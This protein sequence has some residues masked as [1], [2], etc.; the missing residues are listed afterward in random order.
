MAI[1]REGQSFTLDALVEVEP[2]ARIT[3]FG[4]GTAPSVGDLMTLRDTPVRWKAALVHE[5]DTGWHAK[6]VPAPAFAVVA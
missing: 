3:I 1:H 5:D 2:G 4:Q 6:L